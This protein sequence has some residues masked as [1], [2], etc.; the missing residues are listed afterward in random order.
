[1][2]GLG[3][4]VGSALVSLFIL[5]SLGTAIGVAGTK[6]RVCQWATAART[7][8]SRTMCRFG[9]PLTLLVGNWPKVAVEPVKLWVFV[10]SVGSALLFSVVRLNSAVS[11]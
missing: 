5:V 6:A 3:V 11:S 4:L 10:L 1:M 2:V 8:A 9:S 7:A